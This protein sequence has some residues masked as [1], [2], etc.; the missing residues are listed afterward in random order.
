MHKSKIQLTGPEE[1]P[2]EGAAA[3]QLAGHERHDDVNGQAAAAVPAVQEV[4]DELRHE[5][6]K[7]HL[8]AAAAA[9]ATWQQQQQKVAAAAAAT[10]DQHQQQRGTSSSNSA[11]YD[12][13]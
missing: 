12:A 3:V 5:H 2:A 4:A 10:K 9:A 8:A 1:A 7:A 6:R 11:R 13:L